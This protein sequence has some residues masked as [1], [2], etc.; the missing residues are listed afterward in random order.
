LDAQNGLT[1][2]GT[3][4]QRFSLPD[5]LAALKAWIADSDLPGDRRS[6]L[7]VR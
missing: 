7:Y 6:A 3:A 5:M 1:F 4:R 2:T